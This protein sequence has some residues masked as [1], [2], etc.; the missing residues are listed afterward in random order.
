MLVV[1]GTFSSRLL[2]QLSIL[3]GLAL[4]MVY[5]G[6]KVT[7]KVGGHGDAGSRPVH[8]QGLESRL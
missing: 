5:C 6:S 2:I 3:P 7:F 4:V 1:H 8:C